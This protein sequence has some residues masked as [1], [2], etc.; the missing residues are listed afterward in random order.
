MLRTCPDSCMAWCK[1][2]ACLSEGLNKDLSHRSLRVFLYSNFLR[3]QFGDSP[4]FSIVLLC[5][6]KH[7]SL[8][9]CNRNYHVVHSDHLSRRPDFFGC[10]QNQRPETLAVLLTPGSVKQKIHFWLHHPWRR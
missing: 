2:S 7:F 4:L 1:Q 5:F 10:I 8:G 9:R 6:S 3:K